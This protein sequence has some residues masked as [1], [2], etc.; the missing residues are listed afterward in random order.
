MSV[1][2]LAITGLTPEAMDGLDPAPARPPPPRPF[3]IESSELHGG[4]RISAVM[5]AGAA[6]GDMDRL[7]ALPD[8]PRAGGAAAGA[9]VRQAG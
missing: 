5:K 6:D 4:D 8:R 2:Y 7:A 3:P 9:A 1:F